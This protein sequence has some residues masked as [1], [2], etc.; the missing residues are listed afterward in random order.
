M[1][2]FTYRA[3]NLSGHVESGTLQAQSRSEALA[4]LRGRSLTPLSL[5]ESVEGSREATRPG[6]RPGRREALAFTQQM[7]ALLTSG[8]PMDRALAILCDLTRGRP[9]GSV[10]AQVREDVRAG[11]AFSDALARRPDL[12]NAYY[13]NMVR[14]GEAGGVLPLVLRRLAEVIEEEQEIRGRVRSSM[15]YPLFLLVFA[16]LA[17]GVLMVVVV[18]RFHD[19]FSQAGGQVPAITRVVVGLSRFTVRYGWLVLLLLGAL[20]AGFLAYRRTPAGKEAVDALTLR[21]PI[22]GDIFKKAATG[23]MARTLGTMLQSGVPLVKSLEIV[24]HTLGNGVMA[25]AVERAIAGIR[26]GGGLAQQLSVG[27]AFPPLAVHMLGVGEETGRLEEMLDN[28]ART[29]DSE[30]RSALRSFLSLLE[31]AMIVFL[32]VVVGGILLAVL[33]PVISMGGM[34]R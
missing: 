23:R 22:V 13:L 27:E 15:V 8:M 28:I 7:A 1:P 29:Y 2:T 6:A 19:I 10:I 26:D 33:L 31:P 17:V 21:T 30:V 9:M 14:A 34:M 16:A 5:D 32:T 11:A 4:E 25:H 20:V 18:P 12:F 24:Q 3:G